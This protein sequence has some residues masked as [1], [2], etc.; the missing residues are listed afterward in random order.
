MV[1]ISTQRCHTS[2]S[3][4]R[5]PKMAPAQGPPAQSGRSPASYSTIHVTASF[6]KEGG[7]YEKG[8]KEA[9][10][11]KNYS[12]D[13]EPVGD[14]IFG[15]VTFYMAYLLYVIFANDERHFIEAAINSTCRTFPTTKRY[16]FLEI[17]KRQP[18]SS[19]CPEPP[20]SHIYQLPRQ[21]NVYVDTRPGAGSQDHSAAMGGPRSGDPAAIQHSPNSSP[22]AGPG[23]RPPCSAGYARGHSPT[24]RRQEI[25]LLPAA[26]GHLHR[27]HAAAK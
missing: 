22:T 27:G 9:L 8:I 15:T 6:G 25:Y 10:R 19:L 14:L 11:E 23:R 24:T 16:T 20:R 21:G 13:S 5:I 17:L 18:R 4:S 12:G 2:P 26:Y 1:Q 7:D 3:P